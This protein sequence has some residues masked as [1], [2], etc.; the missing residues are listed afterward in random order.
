MRG[1]LIGLAAALIA[2]APAVAHDLD[3][4]GR[5][6]PARIK[7]GCCGLADAKRLDESEIQWDEARRLWL[8]MLDGAWRAVVPHGGGAPIEM[9]PTDDG[10]YWV[11]YRRADAQ[12]GHFSDRSG[13]GEFTFYC[14]QGPLNF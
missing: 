8:V 2:A 5:E 11:W 9:Q 13:T 10:C 3:C 14:L 7:D 6:V 4:R 1:P 12:T